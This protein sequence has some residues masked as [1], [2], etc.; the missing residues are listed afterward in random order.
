MDTLTPNPSPAS[1]RGEKSALT[2]GPSPA[3]GRGEAKIVVRNL[4]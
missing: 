2:P 3:S 1:G 4:V